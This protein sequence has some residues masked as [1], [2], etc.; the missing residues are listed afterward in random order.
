MAVCMNLSII[1]VLLLIIVNIININFD[2]IKKLIQNNFSVK[3]K[4]KSNLFLWY[5][6]EFW[7]AITLVFSV[8]WSF[9]NHSNTLIWYSRSFIFMLSVLKRVVLLNVFV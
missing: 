5:K 9:R 2:A 4:E 3:K 7:V 6:A 8:T 1:H